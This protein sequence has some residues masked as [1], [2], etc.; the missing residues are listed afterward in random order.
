MCVNCLCVYVCVHSA[1]MCAC[2][3]VHACVCRKKELSSGIV[4][5]F[6]L[7]RYMSL[8]SMEVGAFGDLIT[9]AHSLIL[10]LVT[11]FI[12]GETPFALYEL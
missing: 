9:P 5:Y 2:M 7:S 3:C 4:A 10:R 11:L 8:H 6:A 1:C 12:R